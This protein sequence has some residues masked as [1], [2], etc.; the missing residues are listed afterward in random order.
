MNDK[1]N[2]EMGHGKEVNLA[3]PKC[4]SN[5]MQN[6]TGE[7]WCSVYACDYGLYELK[8]RP[9]VEALKEDQIQEKYTGPGFMTKLRKLLGCD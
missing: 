4:E 7:V 5:L 2:P 1:I 8:T 6:P 3:C 9:L